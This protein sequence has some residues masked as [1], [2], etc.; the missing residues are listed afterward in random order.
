[1]FVMKNKDRA[2]LVDAAMGRIACDTSFENAKLVN[3]FTGEVYAAAVDVLDGVIVRVREGGRPAPVESREV[4]DCGGR[5]LMPGYI[6]THM[7]VES[8]MMVPENFGKQA[9]L[10]GTTTA[11]T[12]PHEI[13]NVMGIDGVAFML[14]SA[15]RSPLRQYVLAPSCVPSVPGVEGAGAEFFAPE[16]ADLLDREGVIGVAEIM[17]YIGVYNNDPRMRGI[18]E[19]GLKRGLFLQ[20]H[21]PS[22]SGD[23][24]NAYL[25]GGPVSCHEIST[26]EETVEKLR[27]GMH[28]NIRSSSLGDT[29][30]AIVSGIKALPWL[31][32]VSIC[33]DDVH[34]ADLLKTG[35]INHVVNVCI[36]Q[37]IDPVMA[38]RFATYNAAREY[39]F[40][41][42]G[43]IGPGYVADIQ[44]TDTLTAEKPPYMVFCEGKLMAK[45]GKLVD[46]EPKMAVCPDVNTVNIPQIKGVEDFRLKAPEGAA[47]EAEVIVFDAAREVMRPGQPLVYRKLP[48]KDGYVD[49]S[50]DE[51]LTYICVANR[52]G[53]GDMTVVPAVHF[54]IEGAV[55]S[56]ISHD[57]HNM[58]ICYSDPES[59]LAAARELERVGGGMCVAKDGKVIATLPLPVGGLMSGLPCDTLA[60]DIDRFGEV[61][62]SINKV[63]NDMLLRI[64][65]LA[66]PVRPGY[67]ITDRGIVNGDTQKLVPIFKD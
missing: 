41:D 17:D 26:G 15:T 7:H 5:Y 29:A 49:I 32:N 64:A 13:G 10:W 61:L 67:I 18:I 9:I 53:A 50:A 59:A 23:A 60:K 47:D 43:A 51:K 52:Y 6:D 33:T 39:H 36:E 35:H 16:V 28:V 55:A 34:A 4:I 58:T 14:D 42:L 31:D 12:D 8:T 57:S 1:M 44:I 2:R 22:V 25:C 19:E 27:L 54:E 45:E 20:G 65:I 37:G 11:V 62:F 3:M 40:D 24:L 21:A 56:T 48:V 38:N 46:Q 66:L 63:S 30:R